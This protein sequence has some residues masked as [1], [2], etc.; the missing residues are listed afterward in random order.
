MATD[1][2]FESPSPLDAPAP[3]GL[4]PATPPAGTLSASDAAEI[5]PSVVITQNKPRRKLEPAE[6]RLILALAKKGLTQ[7]EIAKRLQVNQAT[8]SRVLSEWDDSRAL[9][10][11]KLRAGAA[12]LAQR[13]IEKAN[14]A[15]SLDVL[16]RLDVLPKEQATNDSGVKVFVGVNLAD[17]QK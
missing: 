6:I 8:I 11:A 12:E 13:V 1:D 17:L 7:T 3:T 2:V 16:S 5:E 14:V 9:A 10:K 4:V 15:E